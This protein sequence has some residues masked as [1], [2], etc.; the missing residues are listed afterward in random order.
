MY[1][2]QGWERQFRHVVCSSE[3]AV[4]DITRDRNLTLPKF[5]VMTVH[6]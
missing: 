1:Q 6:A 3:I 5:D 2:L 4:T